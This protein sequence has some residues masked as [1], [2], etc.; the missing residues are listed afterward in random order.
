MGNLK[1]WS[2]I[3]RPL[4]NFR[5]TLDFRYVPGHKPSLSSETQG[6]SPYRWLVRDDYLKKKISKKIFRPPTKKILDDLLVVIISILQFY[7][8]RDTT[9]HL[10]MAWERHRPVTG[11]ATAPQSW[12]K[13]GPKFKRPQNFRGVPRKILGGTLLK[14]PRVRN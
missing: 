14:P 12:V 8:V 4:T 13:I 11:G 5:G 10:Q 1:L 2:R 3:S 7:R 6:P 9:A